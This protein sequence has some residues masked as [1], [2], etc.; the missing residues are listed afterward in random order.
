[1]RQADGGTGCGRSAARVLCSG[2]SFAISLLNPV[3]KAQSNNAGSQPP[4]APAHAS[5][6]PS[7]GLS[8]LDVL[9]ASL[10]RN[11]QLQIETY[12]VDAQAG[13]LRTTQGQFDWTLGAT[14]T[15][16]HTYVPLTAALAAEYNAPGTGVTGQD[17]TIAN[18]STVTAAATKQYRNGITLSPAL[19]LTRD[20]DNVINQQGINQAHAGLAITLPLL[21]NRGR[22]AVDAQEV[23][24]RQILEATRMDLSQ[25]VSDT[26]ATAASRYWTFV[27]ADAT[28]AVYKAS[29]ARGSDLLSGTEALVQADRLPA[30]DLN[31]VRA[32]LADRIA[33]RTAAEQNLLQARQQL[34]LVM[35]L[36]AEQILSLPAPSQNI[37]AA[38]ASYDAARLAGY[39]QLA[40]TRRADVLAARLRRDANLTLQAAAGNQLKPQLDLSPSVGYTGL[41]EGAS[42]LD[43]PRA[44]GNSPRGADV[45]IGITYSQT[46]ANNAA[47]GRL[48]T[49]MATTRQSEITLSET[50]RTAASTVVVAYQGVQS[51]ILQLQRAREAVRFYQAALD[52]EREKYRLG[53]SALVD[54]LTVE[55]R[56]T[57]EVLNEVNARLAYALALVQLRQSTGTIVQ[58]GQDVQQV[59]PLLFSTLP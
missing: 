35:G 39:L 11:P 43:Y 32:N 10:A 12:T 7:T 6:A 49:A 29:E 2:L 9:Q 3:A 18:T 5:L 14:G 34:V 17:A 33:S 21:R 28:L 15:Q 52:G 37:P 48:E 53:L 54:V 16:Q 44:L 42:I 45:S 8:L 46:P 51:T 57:T 50:A 38:T 26:L 20:T 13:V 55:D 41:R 19:E 56:L 40:N 47:R 24:A 58:A 59:D 22:T 36:A 1:M 25:L 23:A 4:A 30:N 31:E 27:A